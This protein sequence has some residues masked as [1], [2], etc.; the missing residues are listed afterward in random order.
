MLTKH[1]SNLEVNNFNPKIGEKTARMRAKSPHSAYYLKYS[2]VTTMLF[3]LSL[4]S[5]DTLLHNYKVFI[6]FWLLVK[7]QCVKKVD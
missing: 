7:I 1:S 5:F 3:E 4:P 2:S 6:C